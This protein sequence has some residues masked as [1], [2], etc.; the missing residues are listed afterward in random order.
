[1]NIRLA[2]SGV[3]IL[4]AGIVGYLIGD[5][6]GEI[7]LQDAQLDAAVVR[8]QDGRKAYERLVEAQNALD[9]LRA[10][11]VDVDTELER[12]RRAVASRAKRSSA[13]AC[14]VERAAVA[15]CES[16]LRESAELLA[17]G[18]ALLQRNAGAH[19]AVV[20]AIEQ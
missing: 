5:Y 14:A 13:P 7:R 2:I 12:L 19:D 8:A 3:A 6:Q 18:G 4:S 16:L 17:E 20:R 11:R 9:A 10:E 1:M 15:R